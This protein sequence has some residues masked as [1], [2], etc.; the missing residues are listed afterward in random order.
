LSIGLCLGSH[1]FIILPS[2]LGR[3][4][5]GFTAEL[6]PSGNSSEHLTNLKA[7]VEGQHGFQKKF[8]CNIMADSEPIVD[9]Q[10]LRA[11][12]QDMDPHIFRTLIPGHQRLESLRC[13]LA[14][15]ARHNPERI[16]TDVH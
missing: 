15:S 8:G 2:E 16:A 6:Q 11:A 9:G 10:A 3:S 14:Q 7:Y 1:L 5:A 12:Q 13:E 4:V